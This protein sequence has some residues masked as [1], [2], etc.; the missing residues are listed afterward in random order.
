MSIKL[1]VSFEFA[2]HHVLGLASHLSSRLSDNEAAHFYSMLVFIAEI[3]T[4]FLNIS[5]L[6][7]QLK[8]K[9]VYF[10]VI[11]GLLI[12]TF[13]IRVLVGPYMVNHMLSHREEWGQEGRGLLYIGV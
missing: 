10:D 2:G 7:H 5:W 1:P 4:P 6:L 12:V 8:K 11:A 13:F 3:S 9:N